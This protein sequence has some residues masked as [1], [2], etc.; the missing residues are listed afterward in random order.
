MTF[1]S[2]REAYELTEQDCTRPIKDADL[3]SISHSHC[4]YWRKLPTHLGVDKIII[5]DIDRSQ[6][7]SEE[8]KRSDFFSQWKNSRGSDATYKQLVVALL[9]INCRQDAED[10][11]K[12]L[13]QSIQKAQHQQAV[14]KKASNNESAMST[15]GMAGQQTT[16][17]LGSIQWG[18]AGGKL[19]PQTFPPNNLYSFPQCA[20]F[21]L[22]SI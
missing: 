4:T 17:M 1:C 2:L 6:L 9:E 8:A 3:E 13:K 19:P 21:Y 16:E 10:V 22:V 20:F 18:G 5:N 14:S 7:G 15:K 11:L 12:I